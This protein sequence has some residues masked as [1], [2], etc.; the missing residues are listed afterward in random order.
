[1]CLMQNSAGQWCGVTDTIHYRDKSE[2]A[3]PAIIY[4]S[5]NLTLIN[6]Y[7]LVSGSA[8]WSMDVTKLKL[9]ELV[10]SEKLSSYKQMDLGIYTCLFGRY[11]WI[12]AWTVISQLCNV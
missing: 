1:M 11:G 10:K 4:H 2:S 8:V 6:F 9:E 7:W 12:Y 5:Q 3:D